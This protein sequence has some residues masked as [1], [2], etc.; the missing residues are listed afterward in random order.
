LT[1][2]L[3]EAIHKASTKTQRGDNMPINVLPKN[4]ARGKGPEPSNVLIYDHE[5]SLKGEENSKESEL[6]AQEIQALWESQE[7]GISKWSGET[8]NRYSDPH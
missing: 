2:R 7:I 6:A 3:G 1:V 8:G 4:S 5:K